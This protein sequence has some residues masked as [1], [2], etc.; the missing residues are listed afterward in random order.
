[1]SMPYVRAQEEHGI[2]WL[3]SAEGKRFVSIGINHLQ[4]DCWLAPYNRDFMLQR[5]GA[6][7]ATADGRFNPDGEALPRLVDATKAKLHDLGFNTLGI[8]TYGV[9]ARLFRDEFYYCVDIRAISLGSRF[10]FGRDTFP[11]IFAEDF[12]TLLDTRV[13]EICSEHRDNARFIGY[14][15]CDIP[16]WYF[17]EGQEL[18]AQPVHPWIDDLAALPDAAPGKQACIEAAGAD[19]ITS[20]QQSD[21][22]MAAVVARWYE[23]HAETI[24]RHDPNHLLLGDKLHSPHRLPEWFI[25]ILK[26]SVDILFIQWYTPIDQQVE[27]LTDLHRAT[28]KPILNGDSCFSCPKP[29]KQT[30]V[31]G[32][33][34]ESQA[35]VGRRYAEYL[36]GAMKLPFMLGWHHCGLVEQWDGGKQNDWEMNENGLFDPFEEPYA[37]ITDCVRE[38]NGQV[39]RWHEESM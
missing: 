34:V 16:R 30:K 38:A 29:P 26:R 21:A 18:D 8:H 28:G 1:M 14:A 13:R 9:P 6:D 7:L 35:E 20:R 25:P 27:T 37:E 32:Y 3:V 17:Y 31:K 4:P 19:R 36:E 5:Y 22:A 11:D 2:W 15:Y 39:S 23:I 24:R 12:E 10:R 33:K